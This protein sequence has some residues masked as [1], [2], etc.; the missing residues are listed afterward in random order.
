MPHAVFQTRN[1][2]RTRQTV[3]VSAWVKPA[4]KAELLRLATQDGL[5]LSQT[6]AALLAEGVRQRLH[7]QHAVLLEPIIEQA[8]KKHMHARDNRLALLLARAAYESGQTKRLV[9]HLLKHSKVNQVVLKAM[10]EDASRGARTSLLR[11]TPQLETVLSAV[12]AWLIE[13]DSRG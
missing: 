12:A 4:V 11:K 3:Q 5:S 8:I 9:V 13:T 10:L 6:C 7:I 2:S 1:Y